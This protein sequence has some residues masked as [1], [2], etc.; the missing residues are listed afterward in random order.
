MLAN[1]L[2]EAAE[3]VGV[4]RRKEEESVCKYVKIESEKTSK[5]ATWKNAASTA[6]RTKIIQAR[7][8]KQVLIFCNVDQAAIHAG[9]NHNAITEHTTTTKLP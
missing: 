3:F 7:S 6:T 2:K 5:Q 8:K 9:N 4:R 1:P